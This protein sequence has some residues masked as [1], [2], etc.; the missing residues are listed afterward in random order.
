MDQDKKQVF[1]ISANPYIK[2]I[3]IECLSYQPNIELCGTSESSILPLEELAFSEP[4]FV[5]IDSGFYKIEKG[6]I[7]NLLDE[8]PNIIVFMLCDFSEEQEVQFTT[9]ALC[10]GVSHFFFK[11][12]EFNPLEI[13]NFKT[14]LIDTL[15]SWKVKK[16]VISNPK[17]FGS[18]LF[19]QKYEIISIFCSIG[20]F[21]SLMQILPFLPKD[22]PIPILVKIEL[23][24]IF[25]KS[26]LER[27]NQVS[28]LYIK[29]AKDSDILTSGTVYLLFEKMN[30]KIIESS[31]KKSLHILE[32][33]SDLEI[34]F[35]QSIGEIFGSKA[36][37]LILSGHVDLSKD[38]RIFKEKGGL[39]ILQNEE[40]SIFWESCK[41][42]Y[43][44]NL[45]DMVLSPHEIVEKIC[46]I[47]WV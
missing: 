43:E 12:S 42:I 46:Q 15:N 5:F 45:F 44:L 36:V 7:R 2:K 13:Q 26:F 24:K 37:G 25:S 40:T 16:K 4:D 19:S 29:E 30:L 41:I 3:F 39:V 17:F 23:P 31:S 18:L 33:S 38:L 28:N 21:F 32:N 11:P 20:G 8:F 6:I 9:K 1:L 34:N 27:L 10:L 22:F 35:Y 14:K 47:A